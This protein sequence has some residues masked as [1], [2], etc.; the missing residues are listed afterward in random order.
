[1]SDFRSQPNP[2]RKALKDPCYFHVKCIVRIFQT[3]RKMC[4]VQKNDSCQPDRES[5]CWQKKG[6]SVLVRT[7]GKWCSLAKLEQGQNK[8][9]P[10]KSLQLLGELLLFR[11]FGSL[12]DLPVRKEHLSKSRN[13]FG[14][15]QLSCRHP[16]KSQSPALDEVITITYD[17]IIRKLLHSHAPLSHPI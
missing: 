15:I 7:A 8:S 12:A 14:M 17:D 16:F 1:M 4:Q 9:S 5:R 11:S 3:Q 10:S 2:N 13:K 6:F